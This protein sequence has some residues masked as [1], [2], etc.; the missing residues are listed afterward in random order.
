MDRGRGGGRRSQQS[1]MGRRRQGFAAIAEGEG[2]GEER[3]EAQGFS[4]SGFLLV[5]LEVK[6]RASREG[7]WVA[8]WGNQKRDTL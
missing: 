4:V 7:W 8:L 5:P 1:R 2:S 6:P 3:L